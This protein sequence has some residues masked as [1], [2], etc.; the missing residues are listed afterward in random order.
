MGRPI[1]NFTIVGGGTAGWIAAAYLNQ[2]LQWGPAAKREGVRITVIESPNIGVI[3]VGEATVPSIKHTM[4]HLG[5][6]EPEFMNRA[7]AT[8]KLG[9]WFDRW[10]MN[11]EGK[12]IGFLHPFTG[13]KTLAGIHPGYPFKKHGIP[14]RDHVTDQDFVRAISFV[15]EAFENNLGPRGLGDPYYGGPQQYAY[16]IDAAKLANYLAEVC[17][18]RG[19][20]HVRDNLVDVKLDERGYISSLQ[21]EKNGDWPVELVIDCTGFRGLLINKALGEPFI[22]FSDY[23]LNDRAIP[24]QVRHWDPERIPP[25][26]QSIALDAGWMWHIPLKSRVGAGYVFCSRFKSDDEALAEMREALGPAACD[27]IEP[28]PAIKMRVGRNRRCWVKNCIAIGLAGGFLEPLEST[29]IMT[30]ELQSRML[31]HYMPTTDF[32]QPLADHYNDYV[33]R[34]Y[35]EVR[36]FLGLHYSLT[37]R[38]GPYWDTVRNEAKKSDSLKSHLELWKYALPS[39]ADPRTSLYVDA[40]SIIAVLMGKNFYRDCKLSAGAYEVPLPLWQRYC[41]ENEASKQSVLKRLASHNRLVEHMHAQGALAL[42]VPRKQEPE[43]APFSDRPLLSQP[44]PIMAR[45]APR[46]Q[47]TGAS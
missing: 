6:S 5:I 37:E 11:D 4:Q 31:L 24:M 47:T 17:K 45:P 21:L 12:L 30:L 14:G 43:E 27:G 2:R 29:A 39:P 22:S 18:T 44:Q 13:G 23:L 15:R 41:A 25:V 20:E 36:D 34:L 7:E 9:I 3:G 40:W 8:F 38:K 19:V 46:A 32:E 28:Q 10:N 35:E 26:T 42:G 16:H 33:A 1:R